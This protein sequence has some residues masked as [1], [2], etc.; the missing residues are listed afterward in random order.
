M[1]ECGLGGCYAAARLQVVSSAEKK[2]REEQ[3][4]QLLESVLES[5]QR[6]VEA[7]WWKDIRDKKADMPMTPAWWH[8]LT[9]MSI[10]KVL[11]IVLAAAI[12][13]NPSKGTR[14]LYAYVKDSKRRPQK[15]RKDKSAS[16]TCP[17]SRHATTSWIS[18]VSQG[19]SHNR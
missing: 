19:M 3:Y 12:S 10:D 11:P 14:S 15:R 6:I 5:L 9:Y 1:L 18:K 7:I 17:F 4:R 2:T 16:R 8:S 13:L